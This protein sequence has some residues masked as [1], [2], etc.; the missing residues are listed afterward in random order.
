[1][2]LALRA[3][4]SARGRHHRTGRERREWLRVSWSSSLNDTPLSVALQKMQVLATGLAG[5]LLGE[6]GNPL[7][8]SIKSVYIARSELRC[9]RVLSQRSSCVMVKSI[10]HKL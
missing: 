7:S 8:Q 5:H 9:N 10:I 2:L 4:P 1:V 3:Q 6:K